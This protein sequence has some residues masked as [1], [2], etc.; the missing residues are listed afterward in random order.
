M[1]VAYV[2]M[3]GGSSGCSGVSWGCPMGMSSGSFSF[4]SPAGLFHIHREDS[5]GPSGMRLLLLV[6]EQGMGVF[7]CALICGMAA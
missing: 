6:R 3:R 7:P 1:F 4:W 2:Q 5:L